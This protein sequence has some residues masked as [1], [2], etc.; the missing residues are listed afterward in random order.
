ML[1]GPAIGTGMLLGG[2]LGAGVGVFVDW[3]IR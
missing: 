2:L 1:A 3:L